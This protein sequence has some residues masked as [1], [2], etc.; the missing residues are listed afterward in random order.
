MLGTGVYVITTLRFLRHMG[1]VEWVTFHGPDS[2]CSEGGATDGEGS[3]AGSDEGARRVTIAADVCRYA[4][5]F[6]WTAF[7][8]ELAALGKLGVRSRC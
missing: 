5:R 4:V 2:H 3:V 7:R 8:L 6:L 1:S